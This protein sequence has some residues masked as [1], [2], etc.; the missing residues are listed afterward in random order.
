MES[1]FRT[2]RRAGG[3]TSTWPGTSRWPR[4][5]PGLRL[6][7]I[8]D[9]AFAELG[10]LTS[11]TSAGRRSPG[12]SRRRRQ[13]RSASAAW[14]EPSPVPCYLDR[15]GCPPG[16]RRLG[17][18]G[19]P[20]PQAGTT[21]PTMPGAQERHP[22]Y[23]EPLIPYPGSSDADEVLS[24]EPLVR[25]LSFAVC[26]TDW[27][28]MSARDLPNVPALG[29]VRHQPGRPQPAGLRELHV[30]RPPAGTCRR[31]TSAPGVQGRGRPPPAC[32]SPAREQVGS[33]ANTAW[34]P[35]SPGPRW[36]CRR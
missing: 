22:A 26:A 33:W 20:L 16:A 3:A 10:K 17:R 9:R 19:L 11:T 18:S 21:G 27:S 36:W 25:L 28:R 8:R 29:P 12:S 1:L 31:A 6:L 7:S 2:L 24:L 5:R 30:P 32:S 35:T 34:R 14:T 4:G 15:P 13:G 23:T